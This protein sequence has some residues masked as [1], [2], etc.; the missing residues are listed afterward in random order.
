MFLKQTTPYRLHLGC[1][2]IRAKGYCNVDIVETIATDV[3]DD[4]SSLSLFEKNSAIEIYACHVLEHFCHDDVP[5]VLKRWYDVLQPGGVLRVSV[6]DI[7][8]IVKIYLDN[9]QHF[10]TPGNSPWIGLI[11][12]GQSSQYDYHKTGFNFCWL[13]HILEG[14]GF[15]DC[16]EYPHYPHFIE[17]LTDGSLAKEPFGVYL[18][19][20]VM[21]IKPLNA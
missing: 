8:R 13:K 6:P 14:S 20:N 16:R 4:I 3:L 19:L 15:S 5:R 7:D 10:Q 11:Y 21:S 9:W 1:G 18:S 12:G 2:N 17:G